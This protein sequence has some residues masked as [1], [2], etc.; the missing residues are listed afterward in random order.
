MDVSQMPISEYGV[1]RGTSVVGYCS[2]YLLT[3]PFSPTHTAQDVIK[4]LEKPLE[5]ASLLYVI[6]EFE[7]SLW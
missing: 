3:C 4:A 5:E 6:K 2:P 7:S 1:Y